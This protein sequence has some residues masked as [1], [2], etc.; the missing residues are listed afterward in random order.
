[1]IS[2]GSRETEDW[3]IGYW[4]ISFSITGINNFL[5]YI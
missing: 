3:S 4:E 5:K 2:E 1:M